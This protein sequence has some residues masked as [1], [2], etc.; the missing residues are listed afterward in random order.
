MPPLKQQPTLTP[1][2]ATSRPTIST[3]NSTVAAG[4]NRPSQPTPGMVQQ[5]RMTGASASNLAAVSL[6]LKPTQS[7]PLS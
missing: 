5:V 2:V 1:I 3:A 6:G 4:V 7:N